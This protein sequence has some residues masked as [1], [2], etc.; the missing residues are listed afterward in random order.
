MTDS[1]TFPPDRKPEAEPRV[2]RRDLA[3]GQIERVVTDHTAEVTISRTKGGVDF[4]NLRDLVDA[5]KLLAAS[6]EFLPPYLRG[7]VGGTFAICL[8]AQELG[9]SPLSLAA[10]TYRMENKGVATIGY[11]AAYFIAVINARAPIKE[12]MHYEII[13]EGEEMRCRVWATL[14]GEDKPREYLSEPLSKL[15]PAKNESGVVK[16]S[17]LWT[18]K[19]ALQLAYSAQRDFARLFFPDVLGGVYGDDELEDVG[20]TVASEAAKNISP[21]LVSRL[22]GNPNNIGQAAIAA[23][24]AAR[25]DSS[26][27]KPKTTESATEQKDAE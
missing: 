27:K 15:R 8:R 20:F 3:E 24:D 13:G 21:G 5:A 18:Q 14:K 16:G 10:W 2:T 19:P 26:P 25:A 17:P 6:G 11:M 7:N 1:Q 9:I 4:Q 23:I 22:R 12:R